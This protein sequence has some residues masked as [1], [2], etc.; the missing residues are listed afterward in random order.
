MKNPPDLAKDLLGIAVQAFAGG[1]IRSTAER[2]AWEMTMNRLLQTPAGKLAVENLSREPASTSFQDILLA[3]LHELL[4]QDTALFRSVTNLLSI[5]RI[6]PPP[7]T[8]VVRPTGTGP[9][10]SFSIQEAEEN[11]S[12]ESTKEATPPS[13]AEDTDVQFTAFYMRELNPS[14]WYNLP[15]YVHIPGALD[16][17]T[18]DSQKYVP[19]SPTTG[20]S[21]SAANQTIRRGSEIVAI[22]DLPGC[23]FNP[24]RSSIFWFEDW[25]RMEFRVRAQADT[26]FQ[27]DGIPTV[28]RIAF[29]IGPLLVAE[30]KIWAQVSDQFNEPQ[31]NK[32]PERESGNAYKAIFVSYSH[33]DT[34]IVERLETAY[35]ALGWK[36]LR[37][38]ESLRSG[39]QWNDGLLKMIDQADIFQLYWSAKAQQSKYVEQE[40]RYALNLK[41]D[42]FIRPVYWEKPLA[43]VPDELNSIHFAP[44]ELT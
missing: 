34:A 7:P 35:K 23:I 3:I 21:T 40:W 39:E 5:P 26:P 22:P 25:H 15:V 6:V 28:G 24:P 4:I 38:V 14:F 1:S 37:D 20:K 2:D 41:R 27:K 8:I 43:P 36:Y 10:G 30:T 13:D 16:A 17:I 33:Q 44:I 29:Y 18:E 32:T 31:P 19:K 42:N 9:S 11:S 12:R